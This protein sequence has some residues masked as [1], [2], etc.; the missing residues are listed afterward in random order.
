M[1]CNYLRQQVLNFIETFRV[2]EERQVKAFF[3]DQGRNETDYVLK[4]LLEGSYIFRVPGTTRLKANLRLSNVNNYDSVIDALDVM[5]QLRSND[6]NWYAL[7]DIPFELEFCVDNNSTMFTVAVFD[8]RTWV[9]RYEQTK[10]LRT[11]NLPI[12]EEDPRKHIAV[13][14]DEALIEKIA[15]LGFDMYARI[16]DR[17]TGE[18]EKWSY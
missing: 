2:V 13:V 12:G 14:S 5:T 17:N 10:R 8:R 15:P 7:R 18:L 6:I 3:T 4:Q 1:F 11:L 9:T 16:K